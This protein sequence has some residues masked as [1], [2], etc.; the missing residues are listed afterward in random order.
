[1]AFDDEIIHAQREV[2]KYHGVMPDV[3]EMD[4]MFDFVLSRELDLKTF[5]RVALY[6]NTARDD[7]AN[8]NMIVDEAIPDRRS[9]RMLEFASGYGR[10][11]RFLAARD[12]RYKMTACDIHPQ[13]VEFVSQK[14]K[15]PAFVSNSVPEKLDISGRFDCVFTLSFFTHVPLSTWFRWLEKLWSLVDVGGLLIFTTHGHVTH[16]LREPNIPIVDGF[17]FRSGSEQHDLDQDE[18]GTTYS[19]PEFVVQQIRKLPNSRIQS[20][21]EGLWFGH[22]DADCILKLPN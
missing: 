21:R 11:T 7:C 17:G 16:Q 15:I 3:H 6:Y 14:L 13:A 9:L 10:M 4:Y 22:Q 18:F 8:L 2:G 1:M 12:D 20:F 19:L 5:D